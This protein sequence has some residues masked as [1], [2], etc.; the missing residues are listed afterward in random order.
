MYLFAT[1]NNHLLGIRR[2]YCTPYCI[3]A[4]YFSNFMFF[5]VCMLSLYQNTWLKLVSKESIVQYCLCIEST[6]SKLV[7]EGKIYWNWLVWIFTMHSGT[8]LWCPKVFHVSM[9][10]ECYAYV[11]M[12]IMN[13]FSSWS[14]VIPLL[15]LLCLG[16]GR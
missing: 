11:F 14:H 2:Y 3:L 10:Q 15:R 6:W 1:N 7:S 13:M 5:S 12:T 9:A 8:F 4:Y 16:W